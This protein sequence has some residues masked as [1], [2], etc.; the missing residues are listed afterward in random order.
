MIDLL[1]GSDLWAQAFRNG[2]A[3]LLVAL[4]LYFPYRAGVLN[5]GAEG[6]MLLGC[7]GAVLVAAKL[8]GSPVAAILGGMLAGLAA[9]LLFV[10]VTVVFRANRYVVGIA[11]N[12]VASGGTAVL[13][14]ILYGTAGTITSSDLEPLP[15]LGLGWLDGVPWLHEVIGS[16]SYLVCAAVGFAVAGTWWLA[17]TRGGVLLR[18]TGSRSDVTSALG[19]S[20]AR[21]QAAAI[22]VGGALIGL[23]G[24]QLSM[25]SAAQFTPD[26]TA[27]RGFVALAL[28]FIAG[29]RC[30]LLVPLA[31][32]FAMFD[33]V[34]V[35]L[36]ALDMPTELSSV[37]PYVA[38]L[39]LLVILGRESKA[40]P[41]AARSS[42]RTSEVSA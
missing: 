9:S 35:N 22:L 32:I 5:L 11:L 27:G 33:A 21:T 25:A 20:V 4:G 40:R 14:S 8:G 29:T 31:L 24:A 38:V 18:A 10:V 13:T 1:L 17:N 36:Q 28:I 7:Y 12:F 16:Q 3:L 26:M 15:T 23:G 30:A 2:S 37:I 19:H 41:G 39:V 42:K 6:T 34:G